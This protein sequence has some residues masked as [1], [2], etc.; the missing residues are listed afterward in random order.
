M[1]NVTAVQGEQTLATLASNDNV[2]QTMIAQW[3]RQAIEGM[4][5]TFFGQPPV[6]AM[7]SLV[8]VDKAPLKEWTIR[9]NGIFSHGNDAL[10]QSAQ[11]RGD[12]AQVRTNVL[13]HKAACTEPRWK[14]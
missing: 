7:V 4:A 2:H 9:S 14:Y 6:E 3:S 11:L 10:Q 5:V 1:S 12:Y 8:N 13:H